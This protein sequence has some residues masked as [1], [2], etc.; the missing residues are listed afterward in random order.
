[1][2]WEIK[3]APRSWKSACNWMLQSDLGIYRFNQPQ[4]K[5]MFSST[6]E[7]LHWECENTIF[8]PQLVELEAPKPSDTKG[9]L[10]LL[11]KIHI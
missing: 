4:M 2:M 6:I 7:K 10:Y 8:D 5:K 1:M 3:G 11:K 9:Q